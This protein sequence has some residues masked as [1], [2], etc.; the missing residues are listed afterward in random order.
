M[1]STCYLRGGPEPVGVRTNNRLV[2]TTEP[3]TEIE[4]PVAGGR[5]GRFRRTDEEITVDGTV[6]TVFDFVEAL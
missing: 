4:V 2:V 3:Q 6:A 5:R 1:T